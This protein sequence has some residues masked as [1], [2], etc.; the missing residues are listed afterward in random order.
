MRKKSFATQIWP[1]RE[2][3]G[4]DMSGTLE[5]IAQLG[6]EGVE[7]CRWFNWTDMFDKWP[8]EDILKVSQRVGLKVVSAH[9]SFPTIFKENV[10]ELIHFCH[11]VEMDYAIVASVPEEQVNSREAV[12][13]VAEIF[14]AASDIL[15]TEGIRIGYHNHGFDFKPLPDGRS[16]PW[17]LFFDNTNAEVVMQVDIGNALKGGA[18]P[19]HYLKKYPGRARLVHLKEYSADH[20]P[21]AIG[22]GEVNWLEVSK[23]CEQLHQ[24]DWY[25]IEQEEKEYDPWVSAERSLAYLRELAF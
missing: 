18:N 16:L 10:S 15:K 20:S 24:P 8:A 3:F 14:N 22:D 13:G 23:V 25:I 12:L 5:R 21:A 19:I 4:N 7:L 6:F 1:F 9:V 11:T 2:D 17:D